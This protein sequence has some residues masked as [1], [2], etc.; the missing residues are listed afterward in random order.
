MSA[1]DIINSLGATSTNEDFES[2][3]E[4][5][6]SA[7]CE[8]GDSPESI[9]DAMHML[10]T[11][12]EL[13]IESRNKYAAIENPS[14]EVT[15]A[16]H[17]TLRVIASTVSMQ[18]D[19]MLSMESSINRD[20]AFD[21]FIEKVIVKVKTMFK[22]LVAAFKGKFGASAKNYK[23][24]KALK[25]KFKGNSNGYGKAGKDASKGLVNA[26]GKVDLANVTKFIDI[27]GTANAA[28]T[29]VDLA[30]GTVDAM[31]EKILASGE[32]KE[33]EASDI[34]TFKGTMDYILKESGDFPHEDKD[35][36][37]SGVLP[38]GSRFVYAFSQNRAIL[39]SESVQVDDPDHK[40]DLGAV[41]KLVESVYSSS[42]AA[43]ENFKKY[44]S[45][46]A[47]LEKKIFDGFQGKG[48]KEKQGSATTAASMSMSYARSVTSIASMYMNF[49]T[50]LNRSAITFSA[51]C[52]AN[53]E[54]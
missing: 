45:A 47:T 36:V 29:I 28:V 46:M 39:Q 2:L 8:D 38:G 20:N 54:K 9:Q 1:L 30:E 7:A 49:S 41:E 25:E 48:I 27:Y 37:K 50:K 15:E 23:A 31:L 53:K 10:T 19:F 40:Y 42:K 24:A 5:L 32:K 22:K 18:N 52:L 12:G 43:V 21:T 3:V 4:E 26:S 35:S 6:A 14:V 13:A 11:A 34:V 51:S 17:H 44:S 33:G 16:Y